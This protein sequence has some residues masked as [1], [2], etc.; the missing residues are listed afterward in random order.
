MTNHLGRREFMTL[1]GGVPAASMILRPFVAR[2]QE[3][4]RAR[5]I[6]VLM[7]IPGDDQEAQLNMAAFQRGLQELGWSVGRNLQ[8]DHRWGSFDRERLRQQ[9][10]ELVALAPDLI[11]AAG[12]GAAEAGQQVSPKTPAGRRQSI[13]PFCAA[14][15]PG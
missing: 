7:S 8:I 12:G 3:P 10:A 13:D 4:E 14:T 5:R 6:G 1:I 2:A 9:A 11:L 15:H